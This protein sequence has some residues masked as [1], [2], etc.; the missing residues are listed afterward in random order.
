MIDLEVSCHGN[1][2]SRSAELALISEA[3]ASSIGSSTSEPEHGK[4]FTPFRCSIS[5]KESS[6]GTAGTRQI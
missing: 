6:S 5:M 3:I 4:S 2:G 1:R